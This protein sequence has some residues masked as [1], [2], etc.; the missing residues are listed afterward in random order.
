MKT[1]SVLLLSVLL[2]SC[3]LF[4]GPG[5]KAGHDVVICHKGK[6]M[7]LPEE[8]AFAHINHGDHYGP[9]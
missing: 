7:T 6:T 5:V 4:G 8:A 9:C 1:L 2:S 3:E